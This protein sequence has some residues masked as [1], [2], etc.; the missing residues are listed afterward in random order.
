M[1]IRQ[2]K[3]YGKYM[4][5]IGWTVDRIEGIYCYSKR[6]PFIGSVLKIQRPSGV[7]SKAG[8]NNLIDKRRVFALYIEP[9]NENQRKKYK[10]NF[11]LFESKY[12]SLP[13]KTVNINLTKGEKKLLMNMHY[14]TRYNIK[15]SRKKAVLVKQSDDVKLFNDLWHK[16]AKTR[17]MYLSLR[18]EVGAIHKAFGSKSAILFAWKD[19][20][21][22]GGTLSVSSDKTTHYMYAAS[23]GLGKK[24]FAPTLLVWESIM[25]AKKQKMKYFDFEGIFDER[26]PI[27]SWKGFTRFKKSFG[28][29]EINYPLIL[30][31]Y[32]FPYKFW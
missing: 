12:S 21:L 30:K 19:D 4:K 27:K 14:K 10:K 6:L 3:E 32:Y 18:R 28:G 11:H 16:D 31:K 17:G 15:T 29:K 9:I 23:T 1:D 5:S 13:S 22:L 25:Y 24:L 8:L 2:T 20:I 7:I 26:Y